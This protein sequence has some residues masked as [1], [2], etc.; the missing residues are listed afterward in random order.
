MGR[1]RPSV[2]TILSGATATGAG[3]T[4]EPWG[5]TYTYHAFG[6]TGSGSGSATILIQVSNNGTNWITMGTI[7]LTLSTTVTADGLSAIV[8]WKYHRANVTAISGTTATVTVIMG[9]LSS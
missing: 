9:N 2:Q 5:D 1:V 6:T 3:S 8:P 4:F 7:S